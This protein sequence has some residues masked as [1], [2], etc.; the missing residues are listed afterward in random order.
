MNV[1]NKFI[2]KFL[3]GFILIVLILLSFFNFSYG[4]QGE[5]IDNVGQVE[6]DVK[7]LDNSTPNIDGNEPMNVEND[8]LV[9]NS[10][11]T[12]VTNYYTETFDLR[13]P[14]LNEIFNYL[15]H[16]K[17]QSTYRNMFS[18][19]YRIDIHVMDKEIRFG[20]PDGIYTEDNSARLFF[21]FLYSENKEEFIAASDN[22]NVLT[23]FVGDNIV[24]YNMLND[25]DNYVTSSDFNDYIL[26][27]KLEYKDNKYVI[28]QTKTY[29]ENSKVDVYEK[30]ALMIENGDYLDDLDGYKELDKLSK[31]ALN[32]IVE[33]LRLKNIN[34]DIEVMVLPDWYLYEEIRSEKNAYR[35]YNLKFKDNS[36]SGLTFVLNIDGVDRFNVGRL[37][38]LSVNNLS[39]KNNL[40]TQ[41]VADYLGLGFD[42][43]VSLVDNGERVREDKVS[44]ALY[45]SQIEV[46]DES[47][48]TDDE[49]KSMITKDF[50]SVIRA[51]YKKSFDEVEGD[52]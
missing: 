6:T 26:E 21:D 3:V 48:N 5:Y 22:I 17:F 52:K 31:N 29:K 20:C 47:K 8:N 4:K 14:T 37:Y 18:N 2:L 7:I 28:T 39:N 10:E 38:Y 27:Q 40:K 24:I 45:E 16:N 15:S 30:L 34:L 49:N 50:T 1:K 46:E 41:E 51:T 44:F 13:W 11:N 25:R 12:L 36:S 23:D 19:I 9:V 35:M 43:L 32:H 33:K 42:E